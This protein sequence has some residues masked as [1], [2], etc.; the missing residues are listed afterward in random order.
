MKAKPDCIVCLFKQALNTARLVTDDPDVHRR[1]LGELARSVVDVTLDVTPAALSKAAYAA[2]ATVTGV[3]DAY[4]EQIPAAGLEVVFTVKSGPVINDA[5]L[6]DAQDTDLT[7]LVRVIETG[8]NDIGVNWSAVSREFT[9]A[10]A[11]ADVI[12][13]KGHGNFETCN[14]RPENVY[15]LLKAKCSMVAAELGAQLGDL[16]F[17]H[18]RP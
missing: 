17:V 7:E 16:V 1:V 11:A 8:S 9:D 4:V 15:F 6:K 2:V 3:T 5:T 14:D 18:A 10:V 13:G 12:V